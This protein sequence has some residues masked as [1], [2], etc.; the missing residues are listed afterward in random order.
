MGY[1]KVRQGRMWLDGVGHGRMAGESS[2]G[3]GRMWLDG[4]G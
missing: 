4:V 2:V 3:Q 1:T